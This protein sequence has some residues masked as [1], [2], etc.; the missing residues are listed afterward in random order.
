MACIGLCT[1]TC[2]YR[3]AYK[4]KSKELKRHVTEKCDELGNIDDIDLVKILDDFILDLDKNTNL[5]RIDKL[6][7]TLQ[8]DDSNELRKELIEL[9][10]LTI[11]FV[12]K[13]RSCCTSSADIVKESQIVKEKIKKF[14]T[15]NKKELKNRKG[16]KEFVKLFYKLISLILLKYGVLTENN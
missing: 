9:I 3:E 8:K 5:E 4:I 1:R 16:Q 10:L 7:Q 14:Y 15:H 11:K 6:I 2:R 13:A 12:N